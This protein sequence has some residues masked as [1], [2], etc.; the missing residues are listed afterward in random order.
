MLLDTI[1]DFILIT[2][3]GI[4][5]LDARMYE[6]FQFF[7]CVRTSRLYDFFGRSVTVLVAPG[8]T[9]ARKYLLPR[10][11]PKCRIA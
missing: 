1:D 7:L 6:C 11:N 8:A 4:R 9:N 5:N 2:N 10:R 3:G